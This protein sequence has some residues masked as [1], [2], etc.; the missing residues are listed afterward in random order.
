MENCNL[1]SFAVDDETYEYL[2]N[3]ADM[4]GTTVS[5]ALAIDLKMLAVHYNS[6]QAFRAELSERHSSLGL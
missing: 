4:A 1:I 6:E 2:R 5:I 3:K